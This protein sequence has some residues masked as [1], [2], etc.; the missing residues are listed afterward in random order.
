MFRNALLASILLLCSLPSC[1]RTQDG[2]PQARQQTPLNAA[3]DTV[4]NPVLKKRFLVALDRVTKAMETSRDTLDEDRISAASYATFRSLTVLA[5]TWDRGGEFTVLID[6]EERDFLHEDSTRKGA[7]G[8]IMNGML[9]LHAMVKILFS[10]RYAGNPVKMDTLE[11]MEKALQK[12]IHDRKQ[13]ITVI[14]SIAIDLFWYYRS[15]LE[16]M[17]REHLFEG[18]IEQIGQVYEQGAGAAE[19]DED[20]FLNGIYRSFEV[21]QVWG[22][23]LNPEKRAM[24]SEMN[25]QLIGQTQRREGIGHQMATGMEFLYK[26]TD[27]ITRTTIDRA[28]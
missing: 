13:G 18:H 15:I 21:C 23:M 28:L 2:T 11:T 20:R 10:M 24:L 12:K 5:R 22:L 16:D 4:R 3:A 6:R 26:I 7:A 19:T 1:S 25:R 17:D 14:A 27:Y 9:G 8:K